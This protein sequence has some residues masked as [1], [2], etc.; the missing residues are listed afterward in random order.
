MYVTVL[1]EQPVPLRQRLL[2]PLETSERVSR[3]TYVMGNSSRMYEEKCISDL[4]PHL[5]VAKTFAMQLDASPVERLEVEHMEVLLASLPAEFEP[6]VADEWL[7][8]FEK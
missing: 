6:E 7:E 3:V 4:W 8:L 2:R 1:L 5:D